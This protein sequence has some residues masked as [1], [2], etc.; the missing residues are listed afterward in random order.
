MKQNMLSRAAFLFKVASVCH[1]W[2]S[3]N[4][5][6][7]PWGGIMGESHRIAQQTQHLHCY[8]PMDV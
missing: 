6:M 1:G 4:I 2:S 8:I 7:S 5:S 3:R